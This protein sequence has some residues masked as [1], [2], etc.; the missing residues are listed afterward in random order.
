MNRI[1]NLTALRANKNGYDTRYAIDIEHP[2]H[3][4]PLVD[5]RESDFGFD[6][7]SSYYSKPNKMSGEKLPGVPDAPLVRLDI[8]KR[9]VVADKFLRTN[10]DVRESLGSPAHIR[11]D[12]A[13]RPLQVQ[14]FAFEV[15]WPMVIKKMNPEMT[16]EE[17]A[18]LV[19]NY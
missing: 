8:A 10:A 7:A 3:N 19:P 16:D 1:P 5:P 17:I 6:D 2:L 15:A 12:D 4:D 18:E 13:L 14:K 9:L 11:I